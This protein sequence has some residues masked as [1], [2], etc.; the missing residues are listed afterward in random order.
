M[1]KKSPHVTDINL[2]TVYNSS[3]VCYYYKLKMDPSCDELM[4][5]HYS[6]TTFTMPFCFV[7][8]HEVIKIMDIK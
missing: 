2:M 3:V 8:L 5:T 6:T 7:M 1:K 4:V